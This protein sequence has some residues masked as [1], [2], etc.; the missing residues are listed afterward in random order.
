MEKYLEQNPTKELLLTTDGLNLPEIV[1]KAINENSIANPPNTENI[2]SKVPSTLMDALIKAR[3]LKKNI[4]TFHLSMNQD[5][6]S[7]A[8]FLLD[9][10]LETREMIAGLPTSIKHVDC[11]IQRFY[12]LLMPLIAMAEDTK[13][14][15]GKAKEFAQ[16]FTEILLESGYSLN[17]KINALVQLYNSVRSTSGLKAYAFEKLVELCTKESCLEIM[18]GKARTIVEESKEWDLTV[19]ERRSLYRT[20]ARSLDQQNDSS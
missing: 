16:Q 8:E 17:I 13:G 3:V 5:E 18:I 9:M 15:Y 10:L 20:V 14:Q 19:D 7:A 12:L 6:D 2:S 4:F 11:S 1:M